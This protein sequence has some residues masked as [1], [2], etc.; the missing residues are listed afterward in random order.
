MEL[1]ILIIALGILAETSFLS[2]KAVSK[3]ASRVH[4]K[5]KIYVDTS[6]LIDGRI[7]DVTRTGFLSD[8]FMIPRSV[9]REM[10]LLADGK[11]AVKAGAAI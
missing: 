5:R 1:F 9:T 10:Q 6:A 4:G 8:D 2:V 3:K 7:L 11:D